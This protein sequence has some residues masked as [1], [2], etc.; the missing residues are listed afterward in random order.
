MRKK[1]L[2]LAVLLVA[3]T[4]VAAGAILYAQQKSA[5]P[6]RLSAEDWIE[7]RQLYSRYAQAVDGM[8]SEADPDKVASLWVEDGTWDNG[9]GAVRRGRKEIASGYMGT[10]SRRFEG[11]NSPRRFFEDISVVIDPSPEGAVGKS[12][13][14]LVRSS[15]KDGEP[16]VIELNGEYHD[17]FVRTREGWKFKARVFR[18]IP[19]GAPAWPAAAR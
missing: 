19:G 6:R 18:R 14:A 16:S 2:L 1:L 10:Y 3:G 9:N 8:N 12:Y 7:I 11:L 4:V 5:S 17:T 13:F 15:A